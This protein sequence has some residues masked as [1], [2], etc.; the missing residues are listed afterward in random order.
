MIRITEKQRATIVRLFVGGT[1]INNLAVSYGVSFDRL[2]QIIRDA[3]KQ[4][5]VRP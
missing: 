4:A 3:M 5:D 2:E 1:T